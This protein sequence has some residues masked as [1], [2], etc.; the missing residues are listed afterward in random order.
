LERRLRAY[1]ES[2]SAG[3]YHPPPN[4]RNLFLEFGHCAALRPLQLLESDSFGL[5]R[6]GIPWGVEF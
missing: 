1:A 5:T 3:Q 6:L 2:R 4:S